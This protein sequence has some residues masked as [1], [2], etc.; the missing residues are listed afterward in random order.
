MIIRRLGARV[1]GDLEKYQ[2]LSKVVGRFKYNSFTGVKERIWNKIHNM[3]NIFLP[4]ARKE[5]LIKPILQA[6][7][8]MP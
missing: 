1:S 5:V 6:N 3:K 4:Q 7:L 8:P 2:G